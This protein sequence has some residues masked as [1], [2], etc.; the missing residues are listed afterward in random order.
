MKY[1]SLLLALPQGHCVLPLGLFLL[2][3]L[4]PVT[5]L[6]RMSPFLEKG[7][8]RTLDKDQFEVEEGTLLPEPAFSVG[9]SSTRQLTDMMY[10][11]HRCAGQVKSGGL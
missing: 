10:F 11:T 5:E 2:F 9:S 1:A 3:F 7:P 8:W 4:L 6:E